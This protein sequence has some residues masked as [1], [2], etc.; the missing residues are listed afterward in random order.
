MDADTT[1][2]LARMGRMEQELA[3]LRKVAEAANGFVSIMEHHA[4][5]HL[6]DADVHA[7]HVAVVDA[8][9]AYWIRSKEHRDAT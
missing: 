5:E 8:M 6:G 4:Y 2:N 9:A 3:L 7:W 1:R